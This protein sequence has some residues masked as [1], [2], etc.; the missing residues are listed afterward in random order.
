MYARDAKSQALFNYFVQNYSK[1]EGRLRPSVLLSHTL[2]NQNY[3]DLHQND[4]PY[5]TD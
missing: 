2:K 1:T 5:L 3:L 4:D